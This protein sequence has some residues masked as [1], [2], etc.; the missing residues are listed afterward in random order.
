[1]TQNSNIEARLLS[2]VAGLTNRLSTHDIENASDL[3]SKREWGVGLEVLCAQLGEYEVQ[4][5]AAELTELND[6]A[7]AMNL[8]I[9]GF[10]VN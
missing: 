8:N 1:M 6:L 7:S 9:S 3:I 5:T 10:G 2:I 4:L